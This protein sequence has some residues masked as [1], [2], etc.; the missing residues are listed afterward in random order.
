MRAQ[1]DRTDR[2]P[3][4]RPFLANSAERQDLISEGPDF[5]LDA[6]PR[7]AQDRQMESG[8]CQ[9]VNRRQLVGGLISTLTCAAFAPVVAHAAKGKLSLMAARFERERFVAECLDAAQ[10]PEAQQ[11]VREVLARAVADHDAVLSSLG[12]PTQAGLDILHRSAELTIFAAKWTPQMN[13][14][15][16]DHRMWALIGIYTGREDNIFWRREGG[17][18]RVSSAQVLFAGDVA[19][20]PADAIHS[21]TNPL[22]RFT[23]GIHI[24]GGDF[25]AA[26]RSQ[27]DPETLR[28]EPSDGN[29][30]RAI[31]EREN[32][33]I[34]SACHHAP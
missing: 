1:A 34:A 2:N 5:G 25:F 17:G 20:L 10:E 31:F 15:A 23:G 24:Y 18:I 30:I 7:H 29:T 12:P 4:A 16:H 21:V 6:T 11:A 8:R 9:S 3:A 32:Q 14:L 13:L 22:P 19:V 26:H 27:W 33:R 28:E